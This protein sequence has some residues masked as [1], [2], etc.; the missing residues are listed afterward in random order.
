MTYFLVIMR[1]SCAHDLIHGTIFILPCPIRGS[2][3]SWFEL[4][5]LLLFAL[6]LTG[7]IHIWVGTF[8]KHRQHFQDITA[9]SK[10]LKT[11]CDAPS[12]KMYKRGWDH[13]IGW[14]SLNVCYLH[15]R[16]IF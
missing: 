8:E 16:S 15:S 5:D 4:F 11:W 9:F 13:L 3:S 12:V 1:S 2:V 6:G 7:L 14:L 10:C